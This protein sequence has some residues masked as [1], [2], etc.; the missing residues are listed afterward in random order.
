ML[1]PPLYLWESGVQVAFPD[2]LLFSCC[3]YFGRGWTCS[4]C[5]RPVLEDFWKLTS[6]PLPWF[7]LWASIDHS[8]QTAARTV[9]FSCFLSFFFPCCHPFRLWSLLVRKDIWM[10]VALVSGNPRY[11]A[12]MMRSLP[13]VKLFFFIKQMKLHVASFINALAVTSL[14]DQWIQDLHRMCFITAVGTFCSQLLG[15]L[16]ELGFCLKSQPC[17][18]WYSVIWHHFSRCL[19]W[20]RASGCRE[21]W[22]DEKMLKH[23]TPGWVCS[24]IPVSQ[25]IKQLVKALEYGEGL[26]VLITK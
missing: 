15:I 1:P 16:D 13:S 8:C 14:K 7:T 11:C 22:G 23:S 19:G 18:L 5:L 6:I 24:V 3:Y 2:R 12:V 26:F 9:I 10:D 17:Q 25:Q 21:E 20:T 4:L